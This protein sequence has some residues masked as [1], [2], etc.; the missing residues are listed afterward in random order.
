MAGL[1]VLLVT[2]CGLAVLTF[3]ALWWWHEAATSK[4]WGTSLWWLAV[5]AS[6]CWL[7]ARLGACVFASNPMP[8]GVVLSPELAPSLHD[9]VNGVAR[10]FAGVRIDAL[11]I[12]GDMNAAVLQRPAKGLYGAMQTHLLIG[13]P[14]V[15]SVSERQLSAILAHEFGHLA[16]QRQGRHAWTCHARAWWFR[17][18]DNCI[19]R[20]PLLGH[21]IDRLTECDVVQAQALCRLEEFEADRAAASSVGAPL[22]AQTLVEVAAR[23]RFLRCDYWVK[24]MAQCAQRPRPSVRPYRDMGFGMVAGFLPSAERE[25]YL[26]GDEGAEDGLHPTLSERLDA[27]QEVPVLDSFVEDSVAERHLGDLLASLAWE[28]DR[29][30]WSATRGQWREV[31][32]LSRGGARSA[33]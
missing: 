16:C 33:R 31:Y 5:C 23:E 17:A 24:V 19:E 25:D 2:L 14:L 1:A 28:L 27:L 13:L 12:T 10:D 18:L 32:Y 9:L 21:V 4:S 22:L 15:H 26:L 7:T 3:N 30:W 8:L 20:L 11:W 6:S 29:A